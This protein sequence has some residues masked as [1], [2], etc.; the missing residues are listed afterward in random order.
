[1]SEQKPTN[2]DAT[3]T[4]EDTSPQDRWVSLTTM[5][6]LIIV[7]VAAIL[8]STFML[9]VVPYQAVEHTDEVVLAGGG[10]A[11]LT[12]PRLLG[13]REA[14]INPE[15][16][17]IVSAR[18]IT[19][20]TVPATVLILPLDRGVRLVSAEGNPLT[21]Q[22]A[23]S[24]T[25]KPVFETDLYLQQVDLDAPAPWNFDVEVSQPESG[26]PAQPLSFTIQREPW[27]VGVLRRSYNS[28][29]WGTYLLS[30]L[31]LV[32]AGL[33]W[34][35]K[36]NQVAH[37]IIDQ[38]VEQDL[39]RAVAKSDAEGQQENIQKIK[40]NYEQYRRDGYVFGLRIPRQKPLEASYYLACAQESFLEFAKR[41]EREQA[42][43][44]VIQERPWKKER[45]QLESQWQLAAKGYEKYG[46]AQGLRELRIVLL[47]WLERDRATAWEKKFQDATANS[48]SQSERASV[49]WEKRATQ[50]GWKSLV[51]CAQDLR[52]CLVSEGKKGRR[53]ARWLAAGVLPEIC[54]ACRDEKPDFEDQDILKQV[55]INDPSWRVR[56]R[57]ALRLIFA[58]K[59]VPA[60]AQL[61]VRTATAEQANA[62]MS[63]FARAFDREA[64]ASLSAEFLDSRFLEESFSD[65]FRLL[66]KIMSR[67]GSTIVYRARGGGA[68]TLRMML[69]NELER[70][71]QRP[72]VLSLTDWPQKTAWS[73]DD[74]VRALSLAITRCLGQ[75]PAFPWQGG[76][77]E[78]LD[79]LHELIGDNGYEEVWALVDNVGKGP[80]A[81]VKDYANRMRPILE[82]PIFF[83]Q[84]WLRWVLFL[85]EGLAT[86]LYETSAVKGGWV[87]AVS[88]PWRKSPSTEAGNEPLLDLVDRRLQATTNSSVMGRDALFTPQTEGRRVSEEL[89]AY[90]A[91]TPR[92]IVRFFDRLFQ[93]RAALFAEDNP[94]LIDE[95]D[96]AAIIA[97]MPEEAIPLA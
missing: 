64:F 50:Y 61:K 66:D 49:N 19:T 81:D 20:A 56:K 12:Y 79:T 11:Y 97:S 24:P 33:R 70:S 32:G 34:L 92:Q 68:T 40:D 2:P 71:V 72:L 25:T 26:S 88:T 29:P 74:Y 82:C 43:E 16:R 30:V 48:D 78:K 52:D 83:Q 63:N 46:H 3:P 28:I 21:G 62:W 67:E 89:L 31:A 23:I 17:I 15:K 42:F 22:V 9:T 39:L 38:R 27:W 87:N 10:K 86:E 1:M 5:V 85:P 8:F 55:A 60:S 7:L 59:T 91:Q 13:W 47:C 37:N 41:I 73:L 14:E 93:H 18:E 75:S 77:Q 94:P 58:Q 51:E 36:R 35:W 6:V 96:L 53:F 95:L 76:Y 69:T 44:P 90:W 80:A 4:G 84:S 54:R 65:P 45:R 57:A